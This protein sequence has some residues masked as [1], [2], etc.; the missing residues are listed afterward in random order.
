LEAA[1]ISTK[2]G[3]HSSYEAAFD[4]RYSV[5]IAFDFASADWGSINLWR[6]VTGAAP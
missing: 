2:N 3:T 6:I 5:V 4:Q 1:S